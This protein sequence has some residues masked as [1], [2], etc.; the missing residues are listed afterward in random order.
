MERNNYVFDQDLFQ[1]RLQKA[2]SKSGFKSNVALSSK[3]GVS[4]ATIGN[5]IKGSR[6]PRGA[7]E[8]VPIAKA[9]GVSVDYLYGIS[10]YETPVRSTG[11]KFEIENYEDAYRMIEALAGAFENTSAR[12]EEESDPYEE[13][14]RSEVLTILIRDKQLIEFKKQDE[15]IYNLIDFL[16]RTNRIGQVYADFYSLMRNTHI[17]KNDLPF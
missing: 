12:I 4:A 17:A 11:S 1:E 15:K 2:M 14:A 9:L 7:E 8:I 6:K 5:Y 16:T 3:T 10:D 13:S